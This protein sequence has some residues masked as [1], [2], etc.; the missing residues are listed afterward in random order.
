M[1]LFCLAFL[2]GLLYATLTP[3]WGLIDE[4]QHFHYIKF[5]AENRSLPIEGETLLSADIVES[6][7]ATRH[8][9]TFHW[10][11]PAGHS[12]EQ[13]GA[14]GYSYEAYQ[15][16][17]FYLLLAPLFSI[18]PADVLTQLFLLRGVMVIL[19]LTTL[20]FLWRTVNLIFP[21][22]KTWTVLVLLLLVALPERTFAVSRLNNDVLL[23]VFGSAIVWLC[24]C[25]LVYG[26]TVR[27][28]IQLSLL[29]AIGLWVKLSLFVMIAPVLLLFW[30][31]RYAEKWKQSLLIS[32]TIVGF[33][34]FLL[35]ARNSWLYGDWSGISAFHRI[36]P[37]H[38]PDWTLGNFLST[39]YRMFAHVW[40][41]WWKGA[42]SGSN[43]VIVGFYILFAIVLLISLFAI[44]R[45]LS[46]TFCP[47]TK[48]KREIVIV[49]L[50]MIVA[51]AGATIVS[52][53][54]GM[55][56]VVQGRFLL[57]VMIPIVVV[58]SWGVRTLHYGKW[59]MLSLIGV[60]FLLDFLSLWG[61]LLPFYYYWSAFPANDYINE[62]GSAS[63]LYSI[64]KFVSQLAADKPI[65]VGLLLPWIVSAYSLVLAWTIKKMSKCILST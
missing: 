60:L 35:V 65:W 58:W 38:P 6:L 27:R 63:I 20:Y 18:L 31:S 48:T 46:Q 62:S 5:I 1:I 21:H 44:R 64:K 49:Y 32:S 3:P 2:H 23:E 8:W 57:P 12:I 39:I 22:D 9:Q 36:M 50:F 14:V 15:P 17:L 29:L 16:P 45:Q 19:S 52:Y 42:E 51:Y 10:Q 4:A 54:Q 37:I 26:L 55:I 47:D 61:N 56:P 28:A 40:V 24:T 25:T 53:F 34:F 13:L 33:S 43:L 7:F 59:I 30:R 41:I 11:T